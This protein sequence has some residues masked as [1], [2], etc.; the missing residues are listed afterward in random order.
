MPQ[1]V[2]D[3]AHFAANPLLEIT[4]TFME[5]CA[6]SNLDISRQRLDEDTD[7]RPIS[8]AL[9]ILLITLNDYAQYQLPPSA[10]NTNMP[11]R[12]N[13][14]K[15]LLASGNKSS[16][17]F[18]PLINSILAD[19]TDIEIWKQLTDLVDSL[20]PIPPTVMNVR[21]TPF[22][23]SQHTRCTA[24]FKCQNQLM[25]S[26]KD[27]LRTELTGKIIKN[28]DDFYKKYFEETTWANKCKDIT[29]RYL[30]RRDKVSFQFP[31]DPTETNVWAWIKAVQ[32]KF[33]E[34]YKPYK[35]SK[36][37]KPIPLRAQVFQ[38]TGQRQING[39]LAPRQIDVFLKRRQLPARTPHDWRDVLVMGELTT[40][41]VGK[42]TDKFLQLSAYMRELFA[43]QPLRRFAQGFLMFGTQLQLWVYDRSG[44]Y[45]SDFI[46][47]RENP[48]KLLYVI[49]AYMM[50][51]ND[52]LGIDSSIYQDK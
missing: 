35:T 47:I 2:E 39:G 25:E 45:S 5:R 10:D 44:P 31:A 17:H 50:M 9:S 12:I 38:S 14:I 13:S 48:E 29:K 22:I 11:A 52:E 28:F 27:E 20:E 3:S 49:A 26:L 41:P 21:S 43:A 24:P 42:W 37:Q 19:E 34:P 16:R 1:S 8:K 18:I 7:L 36:D 23:D 40:S 32:A 51:S 6:N 46:E 33:I 4:S 15:R 30:N